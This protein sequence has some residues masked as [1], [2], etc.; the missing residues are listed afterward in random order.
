MNRDAIAGADRRHLEQLAE[1]LRSH[2]VAVIEECIDTIHRTMTNS[3]DVRDDLL[4]GLAC[5]AAVLRR[6]ADE[7]AR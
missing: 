4:G 1:V 7:A 2:R 3:A 6:M 5:A